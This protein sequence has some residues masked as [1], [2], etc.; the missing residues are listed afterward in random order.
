MVSV[1]YL[2]KFSENREN[3]FFTRRTIGPSTTKVERRFK[4]CKYANEC[5]SYSILE[6][7]RLT[8]MN[9]KI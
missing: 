9:L 6:K 5:D 3:M 1:A 2:G 4:T 7:K 8:I